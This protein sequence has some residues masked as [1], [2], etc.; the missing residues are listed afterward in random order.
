V[1][2][3]VVA[4]MGPWRAAASWRSRAVI[5]LGAGRA[6]ALDIRVGDRLYLAARRAPAGAAVSWP[7]PA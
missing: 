5:E 2:V 7:I 6:G 3:R 1:V 4:A